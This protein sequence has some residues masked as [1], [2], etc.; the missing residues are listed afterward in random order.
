[1]PVIIPNDLPAK[2]WLEQEHVFFMPKSRA[3]KQDIRPLKTAIINLMP[4]KEETER[5][6]LRLL[7]ISPLQNEVCF[8]QMAS[9]VSK[10]TDVSHLKKFYKT[11]AEIKKEKFDLMII[12]GAPV[13][14]MPFEEVDYWP[15]LAELMDYAKENVFCTLFICWGAQAGLNHYYGVPKYPLNKKFFGVFSHKI[16]DKQSPL[17]WGFDDEIIIPHSRHTDVTL[18]D[19]KKIKALKVEVSGEAGPAIITARGGRE[20]YITGHLEYDVD[21][22]DKEYKRDLKKGLPIHKPKNY[23]KGAEPTSTW[24]AGASLFYINLINY[25]YQNTPYKMSDIK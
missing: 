3:D 10:N 1:M 19:V 18:P 7:S 16:L 15:E 24:R 5:Q 13:E 12:T 8:V 6:F 14:Q 4:T 25:V 17:F 9:H 20:V 22:L 2:K 11:P 21:T 23:Y